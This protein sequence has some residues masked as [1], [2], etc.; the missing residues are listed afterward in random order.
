MKSRRL[1]SNMKLPAPL[2]TASVERL[3]AI[4]ERPSLHDRTISHLPGG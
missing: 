1:L 2:V 4:V 3:T